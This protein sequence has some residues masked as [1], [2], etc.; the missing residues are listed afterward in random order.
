MMANSMVAR[1]GAVVALTVVVALL[2]AWITARSLVQQAGP[3]SPPPNKDIPPAKTVGRPVRIVSF[4]FHDRPVDEIAGLV[5][6]EGARGADLIV[7]PEAWAGS[8]PVP[9][10]GPLMRRFAALA[11]KHHTYIVN[12]IFRQVGDKAYNSAVLIDRDGHVAGIY[13]KAFPYW[14]EF[15][16]VKGLA[17]GA[18]VPVF[19]TDFGKLGIA[20]CFDVNFPELWSQLA[21][22][23]AEIVVWPSAYCGGS[24]LQAHAINHHYYI[25]TSTWRGQ[26]LVYDVTGE[27]LV[28]STRE[29]LNTT[30][31]ALDLARRVYHANFNWTKAQKMLQDY[32]DDVVVDKY[33]DQEQWFVLKAKRPGVSVPSI[34]EK[35]GLEELRDYVARSRTEMDRRRGFS[36]TVPQSETDK[37]ISMR[38]L[39]V[40]LNTAVDDITPSKK[41]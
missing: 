1:F 8:E 36:L 25:V 35:Y 24:S 34:A 37:S 2:T 22:H 40:R 29:G 41:P 39:P 12:C 30:R 21:D 10:D 15:D 32:P 17:V 19:E 23:Q 5:D 6:D 13:D 14:S 18:D 9:M 27:Q 26:T 31:V 33:L 7:L 20:I 11:R 38:D 28:N 16:S 4:S 3:P